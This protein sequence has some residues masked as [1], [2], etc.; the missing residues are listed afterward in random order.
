M[1]PSCI[2]S[3]L[4]RSEM[5]ACTFLTW[6]TRWQSCTY[7]TNN[8]GKLWAPKRWEDLEVDP[9]SFSSYPRPNHA[10]LPGLP[11]G[12]TL[13][14]CTKSSVSALSF[15]ESRI[16]G[17]CHECESLAR[18]SLFCLYL[19]LPNSSGSLHATG[20]TF[21]V[22]EMFVFTCSMVDTLSEVSQR[23]KGCVKCQVY[24][25]WSSNIM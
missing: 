2:C 9:N 16:S 13:V 17:T 18:T 5:A 22:Q 12:D 15:N 7:L 3:T 6:K 20:I 10:G 21:H 19:M 24:C 11:W 8:F 1:F 4:S 14:Q 25:L 23:I